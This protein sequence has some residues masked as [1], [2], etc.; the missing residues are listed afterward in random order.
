ME[1]VPQDIGTTWGY[2]IVRGQG[3]AS[4][5]L[6]QFVMTRSR[7]LT[8]MALTREAYERSTT[9]GL[10]LMAYKFAAADYAYGDDDCNSKR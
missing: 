4:Q 6:G 3:R 8:Q 7:I 10:C 9:V 2:Y 1:E 5:P